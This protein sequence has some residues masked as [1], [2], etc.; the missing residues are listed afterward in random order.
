MIIENI[1]KSLAELYKSLLSELKPKWRVVINIGDYN[2]Y[3]LGFVDEP[4]CSLELDVSEEEINELHDEIIDMEISVYLYEELLY[5][6]PFDMS[7]E[8][9]REYNELKKREKE[10]NKYAPLEAISSYCFQQKS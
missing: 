5:K 7:E 1:P 10:Y 3:K 6:N 9:K 4:P 2:L 8:E